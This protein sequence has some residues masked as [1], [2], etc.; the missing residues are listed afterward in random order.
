LET[1]ADAC[2]RLGEREEQ[3]VALEALAELPLDE[4]RDPVAAARVYKLYA[5]AAVAAG[6]GGLARG[7][8]RNAVELF[9][10]GGDD[11]RDA[12]AGALLLSARIETD[13]GDLA[14]ARERLT[15]AGAAAAGARDPWEPGGEGPAPAQAPRCVREGAAGI[16]LLGGRPAVP[17]R[18][19]RG[20]RACLTWLSATSGLIDFGHWR[21]CA[22]SRAG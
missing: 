16:I 14:G 5:R 21:M 20:T 13:A 10:L 17:P 12:L 19:P 7:Y 4:E 15:A 6:E 2:D 11:V 22:G 1:L 8:V 3:R 18:A 9:A